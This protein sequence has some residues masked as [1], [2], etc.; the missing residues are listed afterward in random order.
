VERAPQDRVGCGAA[1]AGSALLPWWLG[2]VAEDPGIALVAPWLFGFGVLLALSG[3]L[4]LRR[5]P[6][7]EA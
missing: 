2:R 3:A 1:S 7:A 6:E 5:T 4:A